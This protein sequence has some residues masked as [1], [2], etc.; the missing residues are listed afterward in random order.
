MFD[1]D[2]IMD[3]WR[4]ETCIVFSTI[5]VCDGC[6]RRTAWGFIFGNDWWYVVSLGIFPVVRLREARYGNGSREYIL[7]PWALF[8]YYTPKISL[9]IKLLVFVTYQNPSK[10]QIFY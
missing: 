2:E 5:R 7:S 1:R 3:E 9:Q 4:T 6:L 8:N 10:N